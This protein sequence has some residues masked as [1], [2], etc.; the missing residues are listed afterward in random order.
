[1]TQFTILTLNTWGAPYA[2]QRHQRFKAIADA[3]NQKQ[4]D[5]VQL[6]EVFMTAERNRLVADLRETYPH[7]YYFPSAQVGSGLLTLSKFPIVDAHFHRFRMGGKIERLEQGDFY[8]GKGIGLTRLQTPSGIV[9]VYNAH[10]HAQYEHYDDNEYAVYTQTNL[11]EAARLINVLSQ[12]NP[13]ILCGDLNTRPR[14]TGYRLICQ[15]A[16]LDDAYVM[17][18]DEHPITFSPA[19]PYVESPPQC[20][21]YILFRAGSSGK[22]TAERCELALTE[23]IQADGATAYADHYAVEATFQLDNAAG[24]LPVYNAAAAIECLSDLEE[25]ISDTL[26]ELTQDKN[27]HNEHA[28]IGIAAAFDTLVFG[29]LLTRIFGKWGY[30]LRLFALMSSLFYAAYHSG[31][32]FL[33][34]NAR[35][36]TLFAL[37]QEVRLERQKHE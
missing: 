31:S 22:L 30:G 11:F 12:Q 9:D 33:S 3:L 29:G 17:Q 34:L 7:H 37:Q 6:Q 35:E 28:L 32:S 2:P 13:V 16:A 19:N 18:H 5:I 20:L 21:D 14:Q 1:M 23:R 26:T 25:R 10:A 24:E 4:P 15:V 36:Q 8:A 27:H